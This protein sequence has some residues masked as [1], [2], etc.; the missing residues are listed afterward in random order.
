MTLPNEV[1]QDG[2]VIFE[3]DQ[4]PLSHLDYLIELNYNHQYA[5]KIILIRYV[6]DKSV[7]SQKTFEEY[8]RFLNSKDNTP[9]ILTRQ[10]LN[11]FNDQIF[12][13]FIQITVGTKKG[14]QIILEDRQ[15]GWENLN[16]LRRLRKI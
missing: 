9:E 16:F 13:R 11:D 3:K 10:I 6:P 5:D 12:P 7:L 15:P 1:N 2:K 8:C 14:E 4:N